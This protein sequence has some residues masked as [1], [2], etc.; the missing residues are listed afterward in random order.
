MNRWHL[1][2]MSAKVAPRKSS[3]V[4]NIAQ[5]AKDVRINRALKGIDQHLNSIEV[6]R[7]LIDVSYQIAQILGSH[8]PLT[9]VGLDMGI[10]KKGEF[11]FIE[12]NTKPDF[13]G[14]GKLDQRQ[15]NKYLEA[16]KLTARG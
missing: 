3:V 5:G 7:K 13:R 4:T 15:Y 1:S 8:F 2:W 9:I 14:L 11:W 10:D 12:A 16:K 6:M